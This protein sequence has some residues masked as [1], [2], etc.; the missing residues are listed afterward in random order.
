MKVL[1]HLVVGVALVFSVSCRSN[2]RPLEKVAELPTPTPSP[3]IRVTWSSSDLI[4]Q[5]GDNKDLKRAWEKFERSQK[6]RLAQPS[7]RK[8]TPEA[9]ARVKKNN[10]NQIIPYLTWWNV[11]GYREAG[12]LLIAIVVDPSRSDAKRYGLV[13]LATPKSEGGK[14]KTYWVLQEEDM[15]SYL[16]SPASG[17]VYM[18][19]Y[20]RDGAEVTKEIVW[21]RSLRQFRLE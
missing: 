7:D 3:W 11:H 2:T 21:R 6:Y 18:E 14:Y 12:N 16:I 19:C 8:L 4:E 20:R 1:L 5:L 13:V 9:M 15:E 17:S 10:E